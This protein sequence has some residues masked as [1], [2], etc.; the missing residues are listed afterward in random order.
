VA[1]R[2]NAK[3]IGGHREY[4][5]EKNLVYFFIKNKRNNKGMGVTDIK[6]ERQKSESEISNDRKSAEE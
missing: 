3:G 2:V 1:R 6:G 5:R 4:D